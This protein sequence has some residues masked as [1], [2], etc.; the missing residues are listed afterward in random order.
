MPKKAKPK[1]KNYRCPDCGITIV[2]ITHDC[3]QCGFV[4]ELEIIVE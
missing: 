4:G 1:T 2:N 3:P